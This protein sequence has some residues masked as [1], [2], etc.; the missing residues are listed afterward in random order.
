[1]RCRPSLHAWIEPVHWNDPDGLYYQ[2][3]TLSIRGA[4]EHEELFRAFRSPLADQIL[5]DE[6]AAIE[7]NPARER[8]FTNPGWIDYSSR[9]FHRR[10]FV[11][12]V[13]AGIYPVFGLRSVLTVSL[14][15]YLLLSLALYALLRRRFGAIT[16]VV[17][18]SVCILAPPVRDSSFVPMTDSWG[19]LLET[20]ALLAAVLTFDRGTR[21][22]GA[23]V[24]AMVLL[25]VTRDDSVVPLVAVGCLFL[26]QRERRSALLLGTGVA[27]ILPAVI[28][29]GNTSVRENLAFAYSGFNPPFDESWS[30]V[31]NLYP[32]NIRQLLDFDLEYGTHLGAW[33]PFWFLGLALAA[34]GVVLLVRRLR[35]DDPYFRL[36]AYSLLGAAAYVAIFGTYSAFRQEI[37]FLPP[38][39]VAL[40]LV[41]NLGQTLYRERLAGRLPSRGHISGHKVSS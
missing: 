25:S 21:W 19:L 32:Q 22:L 38:V 39:A 31:L 36:A 15:G 8:Q 9:F 7:A 29:F 12:L 24:L 30:F 28:A 37:V 5:A 11:P 41:G 1:M 27:A 34:V 6:R 26:Q 20:C 3:K 33:T 2:A 10:V 40:A 4:D 16:S 13:A 18:A 17:V 35:S 14:I 23:W